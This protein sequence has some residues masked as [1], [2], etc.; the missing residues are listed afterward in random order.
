M[1][2]LVVK[3]ENT[4]LGHR[5]DI[6]DWLCSPETEYGKLGK[7]TDRYWVMKTDTKLYNPHSDPDVFYLMQMLLNTQHAGYQTLIIMKDGT[8]YRSNNEAGREESSDR[9]SQ[10]QQEDTS[11]IREVPD[12]SP[13]TEVPASSP[14]TEGS[15]AGG[16]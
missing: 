10:Q 3:L 1:K 13:G 9:P 16:E 8:D 11:S 12:G 5:K 2:L 7:Q 14:H 6:L 15:G 4:N